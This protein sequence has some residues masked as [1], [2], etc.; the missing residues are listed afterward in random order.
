MDDNFEPNRIISREIWVAAAMSYTVESLE[1]VLSS[2]IDAVNAL[3]P[4]YSLDRQ[5]VGS[6]PVSGNVRLS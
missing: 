5:N 6:L 2:A 4:N 1:V 3:A